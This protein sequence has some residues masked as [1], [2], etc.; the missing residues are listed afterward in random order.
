MLGFGGYLFRPRPSL[1]FLS[2]D[3]DGHG[4]GRWSHGWWKSWWIANDGR[5][6]IGF[7]CELSISGRNGTTYVSIWR[8]PRIITQFQNF[9]KWQL[10]NSGTPELLGPFFSYAKNSKLFVKF[11]GWRASSDLHQ[12][13]MDHWSSKAPWPAKVGAKTARF[14]FFRLRKHV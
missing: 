1:C 12:T 3:N 9:H 6:L 14:C 7:R 10:L 11:P 5:H 8:Y 2:F 4:Y 13:L